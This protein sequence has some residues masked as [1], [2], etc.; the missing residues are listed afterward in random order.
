MHATVS[1][2]VDTCTYMC[3]VVG[4]SEKS[5]KC[6][7]FKKYFGESYVEAR[8]MWQHCHFWSNSIEVIYTTTTKEKILTR[9]YFYFDPHVSFTYKS[10]KST[11]DYTHKM[12]T[13]AEKSKRKWEGSSSREDQ[14]KYTRRKTNRS[15][16]L[17]QSS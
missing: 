4:Y 6:T 13:F 9:A 10:L 11:C 8:A 14:E 2:I 17:D 5:D 7:H 16:I 3:N 1:A 12:S 15:S